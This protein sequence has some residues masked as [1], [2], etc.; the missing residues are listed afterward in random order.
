MVRLVTSLTFFDFFH[1]QFLANFECE[2]IAGIKY[3]KTST[4]NAN[5]GDKIPAQCG[6]WSN[7]NFDWCYLGGEMNA[8]SCPGA[9]KS[10][11]GDFY[12]TKDPSMCQGRSLIYIFCIF[13]L[14][15][16]MLL[17]IFGLNLQK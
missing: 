16:L 8:K 2:C 6:R 12:W 13:V 7:D 1:N 5:Y 9:I 10:R 14:L 17:H 11:T 4:N 15:H 3:G